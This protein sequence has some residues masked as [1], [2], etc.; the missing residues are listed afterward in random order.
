MRRPDL[1]PSPEASRA[2]AERVRAT[3]PSAGFVAWS[4]G[5]S[6]LLVR[7]DEATVV[8]DPYLSNR[9]GDLAPDAPPGWRDR[10]APAPVR[11]EDLK[12]LSAVMISHE[13]GD[14]FDPET[15]R[16]LLAAN[17]GAEVVLPRVLRDDALDLGADPRRVTHPASGR[18]AERAGW[19]FEA[20]PAAHAPP[21]APAPEPDGHGGH[22]FVGYLLVL[23]GVALYHAGDTVV[24]EALVEQLRGRVDVAALPING[25]RWAPFQPSRRGNME[26]EEAAD[27]AVV[28]GA[29]T[30][31]PVHHE[32]LGSSARPVAPLV[33]YVARVHPGL[34]LAR[35]GPGERLEVAVGR[36]P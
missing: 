22:R 13:H 21:D 8:V 34:E 3:R 24:H 11:A 26:D 17:P 18:R 31:V 27:L 2:F 10:D 23:G 15:L 12:D 14:H 1:H 5:G 28:L 25:R 6:G 36:T 4:L 35:L 30:L 20:V 9:L 29:R 16:P 19:T 32:M 7:S 33:D